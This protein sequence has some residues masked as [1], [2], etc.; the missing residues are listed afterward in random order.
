MVY[1]KQVL[2]PVVSYLALVAAV[3]AAAAAVAC[4]LARPVEVATDNG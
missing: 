4:L 2:G 3:S 1:S